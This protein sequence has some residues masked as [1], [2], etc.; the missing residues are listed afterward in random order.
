MFGFAK[1]EE[2]G[3]L[4]E[5]MADAVGVDLEELEQ[6]GTLSAEA[7]D[8]LV[9]RCVG[10]ADTCECQQYLAQTVPGTADAA[11]DYCLNRDEF[12]AMRGAK[13]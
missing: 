4:V 5:K 6:R 3:K 7:R 9:K 1:L 10:C 11:P 13:G 2:H 12:A 8:D